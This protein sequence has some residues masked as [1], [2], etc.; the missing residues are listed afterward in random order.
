MSGLRRQRAA[1]TATHCAFPHSPLPPPSP[2]RYNPHMDDETEVS[3]TETAA[4]VAA[5]CFLAIGLCLVAS[6]LW[7]LWGG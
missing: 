5:A 4:T 6:L 3:A 1:L 2:I 7:H